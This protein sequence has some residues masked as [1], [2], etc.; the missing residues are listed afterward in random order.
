MSTRQYFDFLNAVALLYPDEGIPVRLGT[1][2]QIESFSPAVFAAYCSKNGLTCLRRLQDYKRLIG[3]LEYACEESPDGIAVKLKTASGEELPQLLI[4]IEF[5]FLLHILRKATA[6]HIV[7]LR[8]TTRRAVRNAELESF[9]GI[10][11][12]LGKADAIVFSPESLSLP[13]ST[14][15]DLIWDYFEP[16]LKKRIHLLHTN[17]SFGNRVQGILTELLPRGCGSVDDVAQ[18]IGVSRR[19]LQRRLSEE[20]TTFQRELDQTR[21]MMADHYLRFTDL[22]ISNVAFLL[23]YHETSSFLHAFVAW[24]GITIGEY[25]KRAKAVDT[26]GVSPVLAAVNPR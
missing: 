10:P 4:L 19:T 2:E 8:M 17:D 1:Q 6:R 9:A 16:E 13:F 12:Q 21:L 15:N 11:L 7:P 24:T 23:G 22:P 26:E 20:G 25:K 18:E 3:P 14:R 5:T